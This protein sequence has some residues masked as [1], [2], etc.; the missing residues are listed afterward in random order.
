VTLTLHPLL[1]PWSSVELYLFSPC[2]LYGL[3]RASVPVRGCNYLLPSP[4]CV[5]MFC[6]DFR[7][8]ASFVLYNIKADFVQP[9]WI[10][11]T[12]WYALSLHIK[13]ITFRL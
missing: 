12:W 1:V 5:Y 10:M 11:F 9:W 2:G 6:M 8:K 13:Q 4:H 7:I 3:Y